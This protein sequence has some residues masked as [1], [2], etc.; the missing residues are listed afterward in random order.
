MQRVGDAKCGRFEECDEPKGSP[1]PAGTQ[2]QCDV[3]L[4]LGV[5]ILG[6][7][8]GAGEGACEVEMVQGAE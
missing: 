8:Y 6:A 4:V 7:E 2:G 1:V 3:S 5:G